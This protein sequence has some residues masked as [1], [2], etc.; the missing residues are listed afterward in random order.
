MIIQLEVPTADS[1]D[2]MIEIVKHLHLAVYLIKCNWLLIL[3]QLESN[4]IQNPEELLLDST[5]S[6]GAAPL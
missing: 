5:F 6:F 4:A 1:V 2:Q 3:L